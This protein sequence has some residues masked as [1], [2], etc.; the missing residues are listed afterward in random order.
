MSH[1]SY[2]T[3]RC[4]N[5][6]D[7]QTMAK[8]PVSVSEYDIQTDVHLQSKPPLNGLLQLLQSESDAA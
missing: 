3:A 7:G 8:L 5:Q 1:K 2:F 4:R 6:R